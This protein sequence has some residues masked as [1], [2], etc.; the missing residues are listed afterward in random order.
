VTCAGWYLPDFYLPEQKYW[1]EIKGQPPTESEK[2]KAFFL[3]LDLLWDDIKDIP[4]DE[5]P[6]YHHVYIFSGDIPYPYPREG[7]AIEGGDALETAPRPYC[8]Q[9][10]PI[11]RKL[12]IGILGEPFCAECLERLRNAVGFEAEVVRIG[13]PAEPDALSEAARKVGL[14]A[15][16]ADLFRFGH[17]SDSLQLAYAEARAARF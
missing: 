10:C 3:D 13:Y 5:V 7:N 1:I 11:C 12:G 9:Q 8:W 17:K 6:D 2:E 4:D 15:V 14:A 16:N